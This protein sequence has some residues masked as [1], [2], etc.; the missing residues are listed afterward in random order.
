MTND[1]TDWV[2][3]LKRAGHME[4]LDDPYNV[5][6]EAFHVGSMLERHGCIHAITTGVQLYADEVEPMTM[7][8]EDIKQLQLNLLKQVI[9]IIESKGQRV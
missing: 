1:Y 9:G 2:E 4:M 6:L 5:W 8:A 7:T 3:L